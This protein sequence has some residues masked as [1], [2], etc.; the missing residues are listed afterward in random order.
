M[1]RLLTVLSL[2]LLC[3]CTAAHPDRIERTQN[4]S[5]E[6]RHRIHELVLGDAMPETPVIMRHMIS[7]HISGQPSDLVFTGIMRLAPQTHTARVVGMGGFGLKMFDLTISPKT[8]TTHFLHPGIARISHA[9]EHI[10]FCV[11]RIWLGYGPSID[12]TITT[13]TDT[14]L[15][16]GNHE[17]VEL[18][19][20][21][22]DN[23]R[24]ST[25]AKGPKESWHILLS[26]PMPNSKLPGTIRFFDNEDN[27]SLLIKQVGSQSIGPTI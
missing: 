10:A 26:D 17:G 1:K 5:F 19:H 20:R 25:Q 3:A 11:R 13:S 2:L 7:L 22:I 15:L 21:F 6:T 4:A 23:R 8:L 14:S 12:D 18:T 27:Y 24:V 9:A 16:W